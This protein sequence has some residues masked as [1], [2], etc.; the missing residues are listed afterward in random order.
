MRLKGRLGTD[1]AGSTGY[2][3]TMTIGLRTM[4]NHSKVT[5]GRY[6]I[7]FGSEN[8]PLLCGEQTVVNSV[9]FRDVQPVQLH[10]ALLLRNGLHLGLN[11]LWLPS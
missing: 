11:A 6:M 7:K 10:R 4:G 8:V 3:R 9:G 1:H 5:T 2:V